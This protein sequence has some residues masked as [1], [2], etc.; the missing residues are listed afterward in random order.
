MK[1]VVFGASEIGCLVA[2]EFFEDHDVTIID[3]EEN[4]TEAL[5]KLDISYITGNGSNIN[6]LKAACIE[7]A[8]VFI[9]C[10]NSDE[11]NIVSCL[12]VSRLSRAKTVCFV[13][14]P[15]YIESLKLVKNT[16]Y[17]MIDYVVWPEELLTQEIFRII[18]VPEAVDVENFAG[19]NA[20]LLEYRIK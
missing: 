11:S 2:T 14:K 1:I 18:T 12:T 19:G 7:D 4:K 9:A 17:E 20:R 13:S 3:S 10:T 15:E 6:T 5:N 8:D 16:Q